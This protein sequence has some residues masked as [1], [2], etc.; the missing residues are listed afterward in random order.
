MNGRYDEAIASSTES[1]VSDA[2]L[3]AACAR[4]LRDAL[5]LM[6][7]RWNDLLSSGDSTLAAG[8]STSEKETYE[9][10]K[11]SF[12]MPM[13]LSFT[14]SPII[15]V[16]VN[17][18]KKRF[19]LDT[20]AGLSVLSS[21]TASEC[22]IAALTTDSGT[23]GTG[24]TKTVGFLTASIRELKIGDLTIRN[25]PALIIDR[26]NLE[27]KLFGI[28]T[29]L[30]IEGIVGW[31]AI[32]NLDLTLD[33]KNKHLHVAQPSDK[34]NPTRNLVWFNYPIVTMRGPTGVRLLFGLDTGA[35][36]TSITSN[37]L[38]KLPGA[39]HSE[40]NVKIGS[41]GGYDNIRG[42]ELPELT[43]CGTGYSFQFKKIT[44]MPKDKTLFVRT[45]GVLGSDAFQNGRIRVD[46]R[47][48]LF[49]Y[50]E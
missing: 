28:F 42:I 7:S 24:T 36:R 39:A 27:F 23:A 26:K 17:G 37:I 43:L 32:Q 48:G 21:A 41:A 12:E 11:S 31:N 50:E 10:N 20:G 29:L 40:K 47:N 33:Y 14:G 34:P 25:H 1:S 13:P 44:S 16:T 8:Y 30:R 22:G 38:S 2:S 4:D 45:D 9:F 5:Y 18:V 15:E 46:M 3:V 49:I 35:N 6:Q 19:W